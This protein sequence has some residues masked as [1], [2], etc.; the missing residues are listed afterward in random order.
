M[1]L[2]LKF[3]FHNWAR[4]R[5]IWFFLTL[6]NLCQLIAFEIIVSKKVNEEPPGKSDSKLTG[7][8]QAK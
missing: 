4:V 3:P 5:N 6:T 2:N 7:G 8:E 1:R